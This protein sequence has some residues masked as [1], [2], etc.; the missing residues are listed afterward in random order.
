[1]WNNLGTD[2]LCELSK[3]H[4][5]KY[6]KGGYFP[7]GKISQ[8]CCQHLSRGGN[9]NDISHISFIKS[10]GFYFA[11]GKFSRRQYREKHENYPHAKISTF[12]VHP[13]YLEI[14]Y[15]MWNQTVNQGVTF[16]GFPWTYLLSLDK[17]R[18]CK[19]TSVM[20]KGHVWLW[21]YSNSWKWKMLFYFLFLQVFLFDKILM[22][23]H[24][25]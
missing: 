6:C 3:G 13:L 19:T 4:V 20:V 18:V 12:T 22:I 21:Q 25:W 11:W 16:D 2:I 5:S 7:W 24:G 8:K 10:Y 1:M 23:D 15:Y 9:F 17:T 14:S